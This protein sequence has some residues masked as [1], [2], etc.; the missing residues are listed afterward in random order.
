MQERKT[1]KHF[2]KNG[3]QY[4]QVFSLELSRLLT[5]LFSWVGTLEG[6]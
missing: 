1:V 3:A 6:S 2:S 4:A 5:F